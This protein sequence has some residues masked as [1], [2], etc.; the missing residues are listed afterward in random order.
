MESSRATH[1]VTRTS[2]LARALDVASLRL[3]GP[4]R[5]GVPVQTRLGD[6]LFDFFHQ[7]GAV[8][9]YSVLDRPLHTTRV[10]RLS[11]L[12]VVDA[13]GIEHLQVFQ[14]VAVHDDEIGLESLPH[15]SEL[16]LLAEYARV[17]ERCMLDD[18]DGAESRF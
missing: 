9:R 4:V 5:P 2:P 6:E 11:I 14:W 8:V 17:V 1:R 12:D 16:G 3:F 18:L 15:A 10:H 7:G 13:R